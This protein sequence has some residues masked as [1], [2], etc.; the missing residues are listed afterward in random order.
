MQTAL[1]TVIDDRPGPSPSAFNILMSRIEQEKRQ[2]LRTEEPQTV[3]SWGESIQQ[4]LRSVFEIQWV[5]ALATVLIV[6]Q[7]ILL[8]SL[9]GGPN[10]QAGRGPGPII[11]RGIPQA[12]PA[13][14]TWKVQVVFQGSAQAQ[15]IQEL[16]Q[17]WN[18]TIVDGP[19]NKGMYTITFPKTEA[20]SM[21]SLLQGLTAQTTLVESAHPLQP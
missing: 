1:K 5:P 2:A 3:P 18:G 12:Q 13:R 21:D 9:M 7:S 10:Q 17:Q 11:E 16:I 14:P 6:G 19:S 4:A 15:H 20:L 8:F